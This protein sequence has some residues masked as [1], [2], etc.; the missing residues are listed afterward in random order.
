MDFKDMEKGWQTFGP[1]AALHDNYVACAAVSPSLSRTTTT[2][3]FRTAWREL[4]NAPGP[5]RIIAG[6][7]RP[8]SR[9]SSA[10]RTPGGRSGLAPRRRHT[11]GLDISQA[12]P[13]RSLRPGLEMEAPPGPAEGASADPFRGCGDRRKKNL[14]NALLS[15]FVPMFGCAFLRTTLPAAEEA[16]VPD[17]LRQP[18]ASSSSA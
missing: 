8:S 14:H 2:H 11:F 10:E 9:S 3:D 17:K 4:P 15:D 6:R 5:A 12:A 7:T 13:N 16:D 18:T 1:P